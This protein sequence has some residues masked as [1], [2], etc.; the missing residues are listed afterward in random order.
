MRLGPKVS[1]V[2]GHALMASLSGWGCCLCSRWTLQP[3]ASLFKSYSLHSQQFCQAGA[4]LTM[5]TVTLGLAHWSHSIQ[6][7]S[8]QVSRKP[9]TALTV[10]LRPRGLRTIRFPHGKV[11]P[12]V[13]IVAFWVT[14]RTS[15]SWVAVTVTLRP[16]NLRVICFAHDKFVTVEVV[17][18]AHRDAS[19]FNLA[20]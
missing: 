10:K 2:T 15:A 1:R 3:L 13:P 18:C 4:M 16:R 5:L 11:V 8:W 20:V 7:C 6:I 14:L 9:L 12:P 17:S 19:A